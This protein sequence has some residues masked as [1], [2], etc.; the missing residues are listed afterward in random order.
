MHTL[1]TDPPSSIAPSSSKTAAAK[2]AAAAALAAAAAA[3]AAEGAAHLSNR[4]SQQHCTKQLK[5][6]SDDHC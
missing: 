5:D 6:S 1:V 4:A 2:A 3:V